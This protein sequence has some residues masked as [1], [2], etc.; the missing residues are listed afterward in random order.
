M[1]QS[2]TFA[3]CLCCFL[4]CHRLSR[5]TARVALWPKAMCWY[6]FVYFLS[7]ACCRQ[8][9]SF[10]FIFIEQSLLFNTASLFLHNVCSGGV[11]LIASPFGE[12]ILTSLCSRRHDHAAI[13]CLRATVVFRHGTVHGTVPWHD[14]GTSYS[15]C[16]VWLDIACF[17]PS[18]TEPD[19]RVRLCACDC[20]AQWRI[21]F[22]V[23]AH[24]ARLHFKC[25]TFKSLDSRPFEMN[26][27]YH[28]T[29]YR[30]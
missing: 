7:G 16:E 29:S 9:I 25:G 3:W 13:S 18:S 22:R 24:C 17:R 20:P 2:R 19:K 10:S 28:R 15:L 11:F 1:Q 27:W 6:S 4:C 23:R 21:R 8:Y 12:G 30:A 26:L 14:V 5:G